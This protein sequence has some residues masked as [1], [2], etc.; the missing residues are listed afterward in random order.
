MIAAI[1][2]SFSRCITEKN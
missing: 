1:T 2:W